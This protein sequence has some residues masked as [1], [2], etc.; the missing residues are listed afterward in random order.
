MIR[1]DIYH[2]WMPI[3]SEIVY[4]KNLL[5]YL[6]FCVQVGLY[7][8]GILG[9]QPRGLHGPRMATDWFA[10]ADSTFGCQGVPETHKTQ[11][12]RSGAEG[13]HPCRCCLMLFVHVC[14]TVPFWC[15]FFSASS[16]DR[17]QVPKEA[18]PIVVEPVTMEVIDLQAS[19]AEVLKEISLKFWGLLGC[20]RQ[21]PD[22][23]RI[24][25]FVWYMSTL[26][27]LSAVN[28]PYLEFFR[29]RFFLLVRCW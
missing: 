26:L 20:L 3:Q 25:L 15:F 2:K 10:T 7:Y 21:F 23:R 9:Y 22:K 29:H 13:K 11:L 4:I 27:T 12:K 8:G 5:C 19:A 28:L 24:F 1:C 18:E 17:P 16:L 6:C 14:C